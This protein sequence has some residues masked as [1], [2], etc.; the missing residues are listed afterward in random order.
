MF[1]EVYID[2][3][4]KI[5]IVYDDSMKKLEGKIVIWGDKKFYSIVH[6]SFGIFDRAR[7]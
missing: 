2:I 1:L 6:Q 7:F 5:I 4:C 3:R